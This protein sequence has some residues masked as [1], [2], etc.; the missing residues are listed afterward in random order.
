LEKSRNNAYSPGVERLRQTLRCIANKEQV[1]AGLGIQ[2]LNSQDEDFW[3]AQKRAARRRFMQLCLQE[4]CLDESLNWDEV[5]DATADRI[6]DKAEV[7]L[8]QPGFDY[9]L[10]RR[11]FRARGQFQYNKA[12]HLARERNFLANTALRV[13]LVL[14][15]GGAKF[16]AFGPGPDEVRLVIES[17]AHEF[18]VSSS[19]ELEK[20]FLQDLAKNFDALKEKFDAKEIKVLQGAAFER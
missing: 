14:N 8:E 18:P 3:Q 1:A 2:D 12:V 13:L 4:L 5:D 11:W 10:V 20:P 17:E 19:S 15:A 6:A 9:A 7:F 16:L